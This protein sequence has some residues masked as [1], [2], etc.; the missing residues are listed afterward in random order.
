M[1]TARLLSLL[2][3]L[4]AMTQG[5]SFAEPSTQ[6]APKAP[7]QKVEADDIHSGKGGNQTHS[8]IEAPGT[9]HSGEQQENHK[10]NPQASGHPADKTDE[11]RSA[12]E[13]PKAREANTHQPGAAS[14]GPNAGHASLHTSGAKTTGNIPNKVTPGNAVAQHPAGMSKPAGTAN[15]GIVAKKTENISTRPATLSANKLPISPTVNT[16]RGRVPALATV[17]GPAKPSVANTA[18]ISGTGIKFKP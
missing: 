3:G 1:K 7:A 11:K 10:A 12:V 5:V 6:A 13:S 18:A 9:G 15:G 14:H 4:G 17:G 16:A 8:K 2:M